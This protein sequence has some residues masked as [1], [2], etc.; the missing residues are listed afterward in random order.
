MATWPSSNDYTV[1]IQSPHLC[2]RDPDLKSSK[3]EPNRLTRMPKVWTG[4]FAQ[5]YE[6]KTSNSR[7]A[8]KCFTRSGAD[9]RARYSELS[10]AIA[11][12]RLPY[13]IDFRF[14]DDEIL[15][16]GN[17][18]PIVKMQWVD[19]QPLDKF[20]ESN[21]Y[22]PTALLTTAG[23]LLK[24]VRDLEEHQ[25]A[26]GDLQHGNIV[27]TSTGLK[28]VDY[29]GMF[30]P[31]FAGQTASEVGLPSY[32]H[33]KRGKTD[34]G[35]GLDRF[36]LLVICTG[37]CAVSVEPSLWYEF[38]TGE[39]FL[40][41]ASD[42]RDPRGS[43]LFQRL[44]LTGD[45]QLKA[46]VTL[47]KGACGDTPLAIN[48]PEGTTVV[49]AVRRPTPWW[50]S[51]QPPVVAPGGPPSSPARSLSEQIQDFR[52]VGALAVISIGAIT[53]TL[54]GY[55]GPEVSLWA[56]VCGLLALLVERLSRYNALPA[57]KRRRE[58]ERRTK[59][60]RLDLANQISKKRTLEQ[61]TI[62][63]TQSESR[64]RG[65]E[66]A[67][68]REAHISA[69]LSTIP[70]SRLSSI[71]GIGRVI[72][73]NF[74]Q[75][76]V[77]NAQQLRQR[78]TNVPGVGA[79][80]RSQILG[81]LAQWE[82]AAA[83]SSPNTL[84]P[85]IDSTITGNYRRQR[86]ALVDQLAAVSRQIAKLSSDASQAEREALLIHVPTFGRYLKNTF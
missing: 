69:H 79:K 32:Q 8:V 80:R 40:F 30:V 22:H 15:V 71:S 66:L 49:H 36:A 46:F 81:L 45:T 60:Y 7:W 17:R 64:E 18:F 6:L 75:A 24:M 29:D 51:H 55:F 58:L 83:A 73:S 74:Q 27:I 16:N 50:V 12:S 53:L 10:K 1:A 28:L 65:Q 56:G 3:A 13:F 67:R 19:G 48:L 70:I 11:S 76:G 35:V 47:L 63:L 42:F 77:H 85:N 34:F 9:L 23:S 14:I 78:G 20:V 5:V 37:L 52:H 57:L 25:I 72:V 61:Q 59:Q 39:N 86:Q 2:F 4:N 54:A 38:S 33:P 21:L 26:H 84:P 62:A 68:L 41:T 82:R 43:N 44:S 31:S